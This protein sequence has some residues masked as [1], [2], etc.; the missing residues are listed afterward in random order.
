MTIG[1]AASL[2]G[3]VPQPPLSLFRTPGPR[4][5]H[6]LFGGAAPRRPLLLQKAA[7]GPAGL[8]VL[9]IE[10]DAVAALEL[11]RLLRDCGYRVVGPAASPEEAQRLMARGHRP[12][13]CALLGAGVPGGADIADDLAARGVPVL[14]VAADGSDALSGDR[15]DEPVLHRPFGRREITDAIERS[16]RQAASRRMYATPPPQPSWPRVFPQL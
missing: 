13:D 12:I 16:I 15:S 1:S 14:W 4:V 7:G 6:S 11:Q 5:V 2:S 8:H 9:V 3:T 10:E